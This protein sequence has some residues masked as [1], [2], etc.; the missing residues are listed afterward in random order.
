M[1]TSISLKISFPSLRFAVGQKACLLMN[2]KVLIYLSPHP[3][4]ELNGRWASGSCAGL[5]IVIFSS[6]A[7]A[8]FFSSRGDDE[9]QA[10]LGCKTYIVELEKKVC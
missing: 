3:Q 4:L 6:S 1:F 7:A 5:C 9:W 2:G 8:C 10:R